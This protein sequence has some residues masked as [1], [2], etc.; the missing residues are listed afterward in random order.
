MYEIFLNQKEI[1]ETGEIL[2]ANLKLVDKIIVY[3][4]LIKKVVKVIM[5]K[6][7]EV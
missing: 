2:F 3:I 7:V 6:M 1:I 4:I 5:I